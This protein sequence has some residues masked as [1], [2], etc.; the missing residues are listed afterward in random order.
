MLLLL[1]FVFGRSRKRKYPEFNSPL[2]LGEEAILGHLTE[3]VL[4]LC[5]NE[6][7]DDHKQSMWTFWCTI[8]YVYFQDKYSHTPASVR[9]IIPFEEFP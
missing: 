5:R 2:A 8:Y 1:A 3:S 9:A 4:T 7:C 6:F